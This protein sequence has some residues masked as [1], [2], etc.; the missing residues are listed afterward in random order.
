[1]ISLELDRKDGCYAPGDTITVEVHWDLNELPEAI[2][3]SLRWQTEGK[4]TDDSS[5][6]TEEQIK[7]TSMKG[8][9]SITLRAPRAP[10]SFSG[11]LIRLN[12]FVDV[13]IEE[14]DKVYSVAWVLSSTG[15][16]IQLP[17]EVPSDKPLFR[18]KP[19]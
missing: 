1:M 19:A 16:S 12:W 11:K 4:G 13:F 7:P 6:V 15:R 5:V 2:F 8:R 18:L 14:E 3:A 9:E 17:D 10:L